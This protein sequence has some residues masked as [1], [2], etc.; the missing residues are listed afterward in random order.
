MKRIILRHGTARVE[1]NCSE[2]TIKALNELSE[3]AYN[4]DGKENK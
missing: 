4:Y 2:E 3:L 1:D